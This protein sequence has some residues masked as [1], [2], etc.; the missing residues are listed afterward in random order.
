[1]RNRAVFPQIEIPLERFHRETMCDDSF[2]QEII[3]ILALPAADD[4]TI[5]FWSDHINTKSHLRA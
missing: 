4:L 5:P 1:M 2:T 3:V